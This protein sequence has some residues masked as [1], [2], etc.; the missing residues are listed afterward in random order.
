MSSGWPPKKNAT[1]TFYVGLTSMATGGLKSNPTLAAGDVT[2]ETDG[3]SSGNLTTL[4]TV[5][6][7][8]GTSV[9]V[10]LSATEMNGDDIVVTFIDQ[11]SP[12]EWADYKF[13][14]KTSTNQIDD[15]A[16]TLASGVALTSNERNSVADAFLNRDMSTG[17]DSGST[18]VRTPRQALR[19]L[20]NK[21]AI[22]GT[23]LTVYKEDDTTS[24]WT[25]T[26]TTDSS[27]KAVSSSDPAG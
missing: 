5:T 11:T 1:F 4:P 2:C 15:V 10:T 6:P 26:I 8:A 14:I 13:H 16:S 7:A 3:V 20:R 19:W 17:T 27:Q 23:T 18:T 12:K 22:S 24:S 9:K 25:A 21:W